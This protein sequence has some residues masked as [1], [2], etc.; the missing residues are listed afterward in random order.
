MTKLA[1]LQRCLPVGGT[2]TVHPAQTHR[3][4]DAAGHGEPGQSAGGP[5]PAVQHHVHVPPRKR[6]VRVAKSANFFLFS[7]LFTVMMIRFFQFVKS[8]IDIHFC[9]SILFADIVGFTQL[10]SAC[11]AQELVK[12]LNEL[13]ARFDKLAAVSVFS[14][15]TIY[16]IFTPCACF[17]SSIKWLRPVGL[18]VMFYIATFIQMCTTSVALAS[19]C[20][21]ITNWGLRS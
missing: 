2:I 4:W 14:S 21:N 12:L 1:F 18:L 15:V 17:S 20:S 3:R 10:S 13:F 19:S 5:A 8:Y 6:Q 11:S 7:R 9:S 16:C